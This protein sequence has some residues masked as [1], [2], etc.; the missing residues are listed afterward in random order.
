MTQFH[1]PEDVQDVSA[2]KNAPAPL[3]GLHW[4]ISCEA[5]RTVQVIEL[6]HTRWEIVG[7]EVSPAK[8][9]VGVPASMNP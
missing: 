3:F 4:I 7:R 1:A 8:T 9:V 2:R 5:T 6:L